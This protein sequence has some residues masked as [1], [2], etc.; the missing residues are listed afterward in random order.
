MTGREKG[1]FSFLTVTVTEDARRKTE[2]G[3]RIDAGSLASSEWRRS[4]EKALSAGGLSAIRCSTCL[5]VDRGRGTM[6]RGRDTRAIILIEERKFADQNEVS[7]AVYRGDPGSGGR[8]I[9]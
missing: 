5:D 7:S 2:H 3:T 9:G 1:P 4:A 8:R 6:G